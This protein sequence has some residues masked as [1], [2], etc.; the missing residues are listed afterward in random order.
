MRTPASIF[1]HPIHPMLVVFPIGLWI[2]SLACDLI[3]LAGGSGDAWSTVAFFSMIGGFVG[4]L[5]AAVPGGIYLHLKR[6]LPQWCL[7]VSPQPSMLG[8]SNERR[9]DK[10]QRP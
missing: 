9:K 8:K 2:F 10:A 4:A 1:A 7:E 5:F 6:R 3:R